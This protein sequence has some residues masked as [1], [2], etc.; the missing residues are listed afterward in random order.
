[1]IVKKATFRG[2]PENPH[3][4]LVFEDDREA[5]IYPPAAREIVR[6][7]VYLGPAWETAVP[8]IVVGHVRLRGCTKDPTVLSFVSDFVAAINS[9][10]FANGDLV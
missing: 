4:R 10:T 8:E 2:G 1:M 3:L 7:Q 6:G 9:G 5:V